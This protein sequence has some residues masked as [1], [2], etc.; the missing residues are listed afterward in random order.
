MPAPYD[1]VYMLIDNQVGVTP[2]PFLNR[3]FFGSELTG[4]PNAQDLVETFI[5][6][7]LP[8]ICEAQVADI[9]H[10]SITAVNV[11]DVFDFFA[12]GINEPGLNAIDGLPPASP[13]GFRSAQPGYG[14]R[15]A[16]K[17]IS[18][19]PEA[20][21]SNGVVNAAAGQL[22]QLALALGTPL[23]GDDSV[24]YPVVVT[25]PQPFELPL[26]VVPQNR[27]AISWNF[28]EFISTQTSR[29]Q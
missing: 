4:T 19:I 16:S 12:Q 28:R 6:D 23:E 15:G 10:T 14:L 29:R 26:M 18:G 7:L 1:V 3:Y 20:W 27:D 17:R 24:Y 9:V 25:L 13:I 21:Q 11:S 8:L 22:P 5:S 2:K